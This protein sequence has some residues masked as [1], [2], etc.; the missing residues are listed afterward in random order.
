MLAVERILK[1]LPI[2]KDEDENGV[3]QSYCNNLHVLNGQSACC[4][5]PNTVVYESDTDLAT[6]ASRVE[7]TN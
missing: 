2:V 6:P 4:E 5:C 1:S 3:K 7:G